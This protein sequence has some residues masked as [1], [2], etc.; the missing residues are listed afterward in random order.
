VLQ[1]NGNYLIFSSFIF[2]KRNQL[3]FK[4]QTSKQA[5]TKNQNKTK[6]KK[7]DLKRETSPL[8]PD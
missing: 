4:L 8:S 3:L 7:K 1:I 6:G 5:K 2:V